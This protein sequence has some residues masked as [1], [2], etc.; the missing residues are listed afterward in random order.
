MDPYEAWVIE[1]VEKYAAT[2]ESDRMTLKFI[3]IESR[4][5]W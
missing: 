3:R 5:R 4:A 2:G 1:T